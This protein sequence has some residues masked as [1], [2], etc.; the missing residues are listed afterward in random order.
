MSRKIEAVCARGHKAAVNLQQEL[1]DDVYVAEG[2]PAPL[3]CETCG[4]KMIVLPGH[5]APDENGVLKF[6]AE[7]PAETAG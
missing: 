3:D 4:E 6:D 7:L 1:G 5:Y 2:L